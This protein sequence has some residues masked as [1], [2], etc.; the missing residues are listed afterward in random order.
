MTGDDCSFCDFAPRKRW[1]IPLRAYG[2]TAFACRKLAGLPSRSS[3]LVEYE[4][5]TSASAPSGLRRDSL[6]T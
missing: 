4:G 1:R 6:R 5:W 2:A 3:R